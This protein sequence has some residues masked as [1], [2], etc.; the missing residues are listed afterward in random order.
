[1]VEQ[2]ATSP[3][4]KNYAMRMF[5]SGNTELGSGAYAAGVTADTTGVIIEIDVP[6][7]YN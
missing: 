7:K 6:M 4:T 2:N 3:T 5:T 1:M